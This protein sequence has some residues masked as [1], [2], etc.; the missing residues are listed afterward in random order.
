MNR[1]GVLI[2]FAKRSPASADVAVLYD[3]QISET[4]VVRLATQFYTFTKGEDVLD[5]HVQLGASAAKH[6]GND[7]HERKFNLVYLRFLGYESGRQAALDIVEP[8]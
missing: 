8:A 2:G 5:K 7:W 1:S 4:S 3:L 6:L